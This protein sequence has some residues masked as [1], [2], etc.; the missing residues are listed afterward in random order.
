MI[1]PDKSVT[2]GFVDRIIHFLFGTDIGNK[3]ANQ[4]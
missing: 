3:K 4:I 2:G 1:L